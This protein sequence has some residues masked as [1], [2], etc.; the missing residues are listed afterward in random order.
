MHRMAGV[1]LCGGRSTRMG[2]D[3]SRLEY[4]GLPLSVH[5]SRLLRHAGIHDIFISGPD[6]I[7]DELPG[8]G[9]LAGIHACMQALCSRYSHALFVPVDMPL[10]RAACIRALAGSASD[11]EALHY[12]QQVFPLRLALTAQTRGTLDELLSESAAGRRSIR[13]FIDGLYSGSLPVEA[14]DTEAFSNIN[15]PQQWRALNEAPA[16]PPVPA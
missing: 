9:P 2:T 5:M 6:G 11:A 16:E 7:P 1:I 13:N 4:R 3:K 14:S 8:L 15:T 12:A 10:L